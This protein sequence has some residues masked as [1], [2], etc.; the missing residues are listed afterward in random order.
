M[1]RVHLDGR[2][3]RCGRRQPQ[4][5]THSCTQRRSK[6]NWRGRSQRRSRSIS[7]VRHACPFCP[8]AS[9]PAAA[10]PAAV[11]LAAGYAA[12]AYPAAV[13]PPTGC[14][15]WGCP[16]HQPGR[17]RCLCCRPRPGRRRRSSGR[18][19]TP[20]VTAT[21]VSSATVDALAEMVH[22]VRVRVRIR[23]RV[24]VRVRVGLGLRLGLRLG[25]GSGSG[26]G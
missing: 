12:T 6:R 25:L 19:A 2:A 4:S 15:G 14:A 16:R 20:T 5:Y 22:L 26:S 10:D 11:N 24:R 3:Q 9:C 17:R 23:V 13:C 18:R 7:L 21:L 1:Y 8:A